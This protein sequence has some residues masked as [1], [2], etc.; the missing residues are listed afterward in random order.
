M[1][2]HGSRT[3][4]EWKSTLLRGLHPAKQDSQEGMPPRTFRGR[5]SLQACGQ[6]AKNGFWHFSLTERSKPLTCFSAPFGRFAFNRL[7]FWPVFCKRHLPKKKEKKKRHLPK[8][9]T[10]SKGSDIFQRTMS[11]ILAGLPGVVCHMDDIWVHATDRKTHDQRLRAVLQRLSEAGL[12]LNEKCD[13][14]RTMINFLGHIID[15]D[16]VGADPAKISGIMNFPATKNVPEFQRFFDK[17][18]QLTKFTKD[19]AKETATAQKRH[20][21]MEGGPSNNRKWLSRKENQPS[22]PHQ[23][24]HT[25]TSTKRRS[26]QQTHLWHQLAEGKGHETA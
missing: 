25:M 8:K 17:V 4:T 23:C 14:A 26:S 9:A 11:Q 13:F 15:G 1:L 19:L 7:P 16:G 12:T 2:R 22:R 24:S 20:L 18:N 6:H 21:D 10:S 5:K 3:Q